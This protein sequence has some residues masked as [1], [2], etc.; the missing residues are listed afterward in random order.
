MYL[1]KRNHLL[2]NWLHP[3]YS[4]DSKVWR[5]NLDIEESEKTYKILTDLPGLSREDLKL[6][7]ENNVLT[8]SGERKSEREDKEN[9]YLYRERCTGKFK[10]AFALPE[11]TKADEIKANLKNGVL[12]LTIPKEEKAKAKKIEIK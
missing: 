9:G 5:P 7:V 3:D 1:I 8:I 12:S 6:S 11:N 2:D 10:R 4:K